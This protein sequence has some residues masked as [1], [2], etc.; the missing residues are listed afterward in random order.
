MIPE[1]RGVRV[2]ISE[3][4]IRMAVEMAEREHGEGNSE[5]V[6][7]DKTCNFPCSTKK[8]L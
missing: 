7:A 6:S 8:F 3:E 4:R 1:G 5:E 2:R